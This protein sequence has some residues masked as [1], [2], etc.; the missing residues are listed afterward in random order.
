VV[1]GHEGNGKKMIYTPKEKFMYLVRKN[2]A[3]EK[4]K[5]QF[6]LELE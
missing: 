2:P 3:L 6:N 5:Q 4:L 1:E